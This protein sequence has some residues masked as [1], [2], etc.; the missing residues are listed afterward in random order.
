MTTRLRHL[1]PP[2]IAA[3]AML[4][5]SAAA[6]ARDFDDI[7]C[8]NGLF[9]DYPPFQVAEVTGSERAYFLD[10]LDGCPAAPDCRTAS[11]P[12]VV[13]GDR[14]VLGRVTGDFVCAYFY[15]DV[16]GTAGY[17]PLDRVRLVPA[18]SS[19]ASQLAWLGSWRGAG[20]QDIV[21]TR[22]AGRM[23]VRGSAFW[24][25]MPTSDGHPVIHDGE[26]SG[27]LVLLGNRG[28]YDDGY[29]KVDFTLLGD[30]LLASDN[31]GCGGVNVTFTSVYLQ[32][33]H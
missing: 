21:I 31:R 3:C 6:A 32:Q 26:L 18:V 10:D 5:M 33:D 1:A 4:T 11:Q 29:C 15:N 17:L 12:Y 27:E 28:F 30:F 2:A 23:V 22:E 14:L 9:A 8:R 20:D 7:S 16:G 24:Q 19:N 13:A 25:G